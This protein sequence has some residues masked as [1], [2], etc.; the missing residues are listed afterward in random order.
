MG[1]ETDVRGSTVND[2]LTFAGGWGGGVRRGCD[3]S[4][5]GDSSVDDHFNFSK[6]SGGGGVSDDSS[7]D[8]YVT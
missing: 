2:Y 6:G 1:S 7:V 4:V 8:D 3:D 5:V